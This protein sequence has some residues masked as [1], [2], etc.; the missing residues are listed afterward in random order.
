MTVC[1]YFKQGNCRNGPRCSFEH[2]REYKQ[3]TTASSSAFATSSNSLF[4]KSSSPEVNE[5]ISEETI[6]TSLTTEAPQWPLT[7]FC[8]IR[9]GQKNLI[10]NQDASFEEVR[11][12]A[13]EAIRS[14]T[15]PAYEASLNSRI[16]QKNMQVQN[17]LQNIRQTVQYARSMSTST[18]A[19]NTGSV[20][21]SSNSAFANNASIANDNPFSMSGNPTS[22][23]FMTNNSNTSQTPSLFNNMTQPPSNTLSGFS[24]NSSNN[25]PQSVF[26]QTATFNNSSPGSSSV[27]QSTA[28]SGAFQTGQQ[29]TFGQP[30]FGQSAFGQPAFAQT[31]QNVSAFGQPAQTSTFGQSSFSQG[32]NT[33]SAFT[34]PQSSQS[35][36]G[37]PNS[38]VGNTG[39]SPA[40]T[41]PFGQSLNGFGGA[42]SSV[43]GSSPFGQSITN[44]PATGNDVS[45]FSNQNSFGTPQVQTN[46]MVMEPSTGQETAKS[47]FGSLASPAINQMPKSQS[48]FSN[49]SLSSQAASARSND[50]DDG[51]PA[52]TRN[53]FS[54]NTSFS[55]NGPRRFPPVSKAFQQQIRDSAEQ[56]SAEEIEQYKLPQFGPGKV[57]ETPPTLDLIQ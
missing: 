34:Q 24:S 19:Q 9:Y 23:S 56:L 29:S 44:T 1:R 18:Q 7:C 5:E 54:K 32:T 8:P 26:G 25:T 20:F 57:P 37:Q 50:K 36:F 46:D 35:G 3:G 31:S 52:I 6:K 53:A 11:A 16:Q 28:P 21:G 41:A 4:A 49:T 10:E 12:G 48:A 17:L 30:A 38:A 13:Y 15:F 33:T 42:S 51:S 27:F 14:N 47:A 45:A 22:N 2:P 39:N 55:L 43:F 40:Q